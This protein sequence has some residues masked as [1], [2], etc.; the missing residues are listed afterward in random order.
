MT[1]KTVHIASISCGHCIATI[2]RELLDLPGVNSVKGDPGTKL[3]TVRWD[4][5]ADWKAIA[6]T[7]DEIGFPPDAA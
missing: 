1:E 2:T 3:V 7:L 5:P 6:A 4:P